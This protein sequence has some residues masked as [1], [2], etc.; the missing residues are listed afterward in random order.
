MYFFF[1]RAEIFKKELKNWYTDFKN[2]NLIA[3]IFFKT[4]INDRNIQF[5]QQI[6]I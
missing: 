3:E 2:I 5:S 4:K 6:C 1:K